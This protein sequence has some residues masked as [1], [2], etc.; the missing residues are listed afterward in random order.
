[1]L[2]NNGDAAITFCLQEAL[3]KK[4]YEVKIATHYFKTVKKQYPQKPIVREP[5]TSV[6]QK[7]ARRFGIAP[8]LL[9]TLAFQF[10]PTV[11]ACDFLIAVPGGYLNS[12]YG[13]SR[14]AK[15]IITAKKMGKRTA[16]YAQSV[17]PLNKTDKEWFEKLYS[18]LDFIFLRDQSSF[19]LV[20]KLGLKDRKKYFLTVDTA[21]LLPFSPVMQPVCQKVIAI[22]VREWHY[23]GRNQNQYFNLIGSFVEILVA[24]GFDVEFISTCQGLKEYRDDSKTAQQIMLQLG[25]AIQS[26]VS[27]N[28]QYYKVED[29]KNYLSKFHAVIGTR[30]H[31]C[32]LSMMKGIPAFNISYEIKGREVYRYCHLAE[33][34]VDYN[35]AIEKGKNQLLHFLNNLNSIKDRLP[36][37]W[38]EKRKIALTDFDFFVDHFI[39]NQNQEKEWN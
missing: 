8:N 31:F 20:N 13:F 37:I 4:G 10:N 6:W 26:H 34:S 23:D 7:L 24:Q 36:A 18:F 1:M 29:L 39:L 3:E 12:Y 33:Y 2:V 27:I 11:K 14:I 17:G 21:F 32:I 15:G 16:V 25:K 22:S 28:E 5:G 19:D 38:E 30:L 9:M 35:E